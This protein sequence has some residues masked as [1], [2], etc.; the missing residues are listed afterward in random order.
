V[1][2]R[3]VQKLL[4]TF[5]S[6]ERVRQATEESLAGVI[7]PAAARRVRTSLAAGLEVGR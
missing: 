1:G 6:L 5:G 7:G 4:R 3:T 2:E